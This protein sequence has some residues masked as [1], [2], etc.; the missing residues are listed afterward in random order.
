VDTRPEKLEARGEKK[1]WNGG[2]ETKGGGKAGKAARGVTRACYPQGSAIHG[3][4][5]KGRGWDN[6]WEGKKGEEMWGAVSVT[7]Q[8]DS[9]GSGLGTPR[10][11]W[12]APDF[13]T[14]TIPNTPK[15]SRLAMGKETP[16]R[17]VRPV[18]G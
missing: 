10:G 3:P 8:C 5:V 1:H 4:R 17:D 15:R 12:R 9:T 13:Q 7:C 14:G 2:A 18:L 11:N 16:R 6:D